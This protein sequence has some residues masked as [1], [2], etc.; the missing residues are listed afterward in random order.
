MTKNLYILILSCYLTALSFHLI[1]GFF[2]F[3]KPPLAHLERPV[4]TSKGVF[5]AAFSLLV[6]SR[7]CALYHCSSFVILF[8]HPSEPPLKKEREILSNF[9]IFLTLFFPSLNVMISADEVFL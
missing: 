9:R 8:R 3:S 2:F 7:L 1:L 4:F 5:P 6:M